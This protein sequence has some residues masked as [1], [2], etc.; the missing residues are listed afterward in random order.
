V[1]Y[2]ALVVDTD[3]DA[4]LATSRL[5]AGA[6]YVV[7]P[8]STFADAKRQLVTARP[9]VLVTTVRLAGYNGLHLVISSH[10][11][12]PD[13]VSVVT[14]STPDAALQADALQLGALYFS[15]PV[16]HKLLL[17]AVAQSLDARGPRPMRRIVRRWYRKRL[18]HR[19]QAR[20]CTRTGIVV[21]ICYGG[22]LLQLRNPVKELPLSNDPI[23]FAPDLRLRARRVWTRAACADGP[24][25]YGLELDP[26]P[27]AAQDAWQAFVDG[28]N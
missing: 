14:H 16:D 18:V 13:L 21:D 20:L 4:L 26:P 19:V 23:V 12:L 10:A 3:R 1:R 7:A 9:D 8:A 2:T 6:G 22:T 24:W 17:D 5:L 15:A 11:L 25:W 28:V 27:P